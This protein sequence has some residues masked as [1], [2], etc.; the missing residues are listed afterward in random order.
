MDNIL[1]S[2]ALAFLITFFA[3][4]IIIQVAKDKKLFDEPDE[5]KVHKA[6]IP[7]LGGIG[8]FAGFIIATLMG[9]PAGIAS[10]LQYFAAAA[11][12]IFFLGLKDD[13]LILSASKK[14]IGQ[15]IAAGIIIKFGGVQLHN[16]HGFLGIYEI[17]H[18][19]SIVLTIF[20]IIVITNSFNLI[21][22]VD[23]LAGSLGVLTTL[24]FGTY[25]FIAGQLAY[26]VMAFA[27]AGSIIAFLIYNFSPAKIFMGDTG[28]LLLGLINSIL[29]IKF[30]NIA[31]N[32]VASF[33][34]EASP[35]IGF[36]ILMIP[37]FDTLR[38]FALRILDRRSPFSPD[39]THVHHFL[40]DLGLNHR[41]V[42]FTCVAANIVFIALA[43]FLRHLGT[44]TLLGILL[45]SAFIFIGVIYYSRPK[46]RAIAKNKSNTS[47]ANTSIIKSHKILSLAPESVEAE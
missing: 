21:D 28:S 25:F 27:L 12:V 11:T 6:V 18:I 24:V 35:A 45:V 5:R 19:A 13:I 26:A 43:Y 15:L 29:V 9:V 8:I 41:M 36:A 20:T 42:T 10:E 17:P 30:I 14:F 47:I 22:G 1:L 16:M 37:L 38:V 46:N 2:A 7:T 44:T 40:L 32:P 31:G 4:P 34:L 33:G 23:G 3:I 39:R